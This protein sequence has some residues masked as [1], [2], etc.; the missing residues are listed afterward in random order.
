MKT[1]YIKAFKLYHIQ[2][3]VEA[4]KVYVESQA[5]DEKYNEIF[6]RWF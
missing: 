3:N 5:W 1:R 4:T 6:N 2:K